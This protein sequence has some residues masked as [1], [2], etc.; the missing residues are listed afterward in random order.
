VPDGIDCAATHGVVGGRNP[1][2][3]KDRND[4][5]I[6]QQLGGALAGLSRQALRIRCASKINGQKMRLHLGDC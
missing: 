6:C 2:A 3:R 4:L 1:A 5:S